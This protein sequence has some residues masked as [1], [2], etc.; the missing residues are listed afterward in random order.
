MQAWILNEAAFDLRALGRL[1]EAVAPMRA[2]LE[3]CVAL[4]AWR[5]A[6][7]RA[8]NLSELHLTLG[9]VAEAVAMGE[10]S[11]G[12]A[13]RSGD[14]FERMYSR[15]SWADALH[16]AGEEGRAQALFEGAEALQA[17][18]QPE[19]PRLYA[20]QGYQY[21]DLLLARGRAAEVRE[22]AAQTLEWASKSS[23]ICS[24]SRWITCPLAGRRW[25]WASLARP[26]RSS[27]RR[28]TACAR[29]VT[30]T[31]YRGAC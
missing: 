30:F 3:R 8:G 24:A 18:T 26:G 1:R 21:C 22:R 12:H 14:A 11:V 23:R 20:L 9:D 7:V 13:D 25:R 6:A 19:Y 16:R 10:A 27:T 31:L 17:E 29:R 28:S 2:W 15:I 5:E 4:E